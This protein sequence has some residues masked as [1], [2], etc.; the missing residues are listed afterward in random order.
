MKDKP[1]ARFVSSDLEK[2]LD[3]LNESK[4]AVIEGNML[5]EHGMR[6]RAFSMKEDRII[7]I[8]DLSGYASGQLADKLTI[9]ES[10]KGDPYGLDALGKDLHVKAKSSVFE[11]IGGL[12]PAQNILSKRP[13]TTEAERTRKDEYYASLLNLDD[14]EHKFVTPTKKVGDKS[15]DICFYTDPTTISPKN[16]NGVQFAYKDSEGQYFSN[17]EKSDTKLD[18]ERLSGLQDVKVFA[19]KKTGLPLIPDYDTAIHGSKKSSIDKEFDPDLGF[20]RPE[21]KVI[22]HKLQKETH[23]M[24]RHGADTENPVGYKFEMTKETPYTMYTPDGKIHSIDNEQSYVDFVN[25]HRDKG[26]D[27]VL[28]PRTGV[29]LNKE[30]KYVLPPEDMRINYEQIDK[31]IAKLGAEGKNDQMKLAKKIS[32]QDIAYKQLIAVVPEAAHAMEVE[33]AHQKGAEAPSF[34]AFKAK[35]DERKTLAKAEL[36]STMQSYS[37]EFGEPSPTEKQYQERKAK[38]A[39]R[40]ASKGVSEMAPVQKSEALPQ[41]KTKGSS[42]PQ[43]QGPGAREAAEIIRK[44]SVDKM[45]AVFERKDTPPSPALTTRSRSNI[46]AQQSSKN[47]DRSQALLHGRSEKRVEIER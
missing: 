39:E 29:E 14:S 16:P 13:E 1:V 5:G 6:L 12:I 44:G 33:K 27:L 23:N 42:G 25:V 40:G 7:G 41:E 15:Y 47:S 4:H 28:N 11:E 30:G 20:M 2:K 8:R 26:Y 36:K 21:E 22:I 19:D 17:P 24:I 34:N 10:A 46:V 37:A 43:M 31:D 45:R 3:S 18:P 32:N 9:G 35:L 38:I